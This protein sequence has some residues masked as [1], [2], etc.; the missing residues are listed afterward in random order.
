MALFA[1]GLDT[2][3]E[4]EITAVTVN[5]DRPEPSH[6]FA[7]KFTLGFRERRVDGALELSRTEALPN[8]ITLSGSRGGLTFLVGLDN[9]VR[10]TADGISVVL[11]AAREQAHPLESVDLQ[12]QRILLDED[13]TFDAD[14][15]LGQIKILETLTNA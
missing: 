3:S 1:A 10:L 13:D 8:V 4:P 7:A 12:F 5:R 14:R 6:H 9:R 2:L 11:D 15:F